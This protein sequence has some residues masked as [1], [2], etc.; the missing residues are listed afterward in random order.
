[1]TMDMTFYEVLSIS[2]QAHKYEIKDAYHKLALRC[3]PDKNPGDIKAVAMMQKINE[4]H[5][6]LYNDH[7]R[8]LY[9]AKLRL[10]R[11]FAGTSHQH[12]AQEH[13]GYQG[14]RK[15]QAYEE[16]QKKQAEQQKQA[17]LQ[18][19]ALGK[20]IIM[21][22]L[23]A[24]SKALEEG[25]RGL[26]DA[27][28]GQ[29]EKDKQA[30]EGFASFTTPFTTLGIDEES[31]QR[32]QEIL[33]QRIRLSVKLGQVKKQLAGHEVEH[34]K[35]LDDLREA[36]AKVWARREEEEDKERE[37]EEAREQEEAAKKAEAAQNEADEKVR[38]EAAAAEAKLRERIWMYRKQDLEERLARNAREEKET[39][40]SAH[41]QSSQVRPSHPWE[42]ALHSDGNSIQASPQDFEACSHSK[43][44]SRVMGKYGC[45]NCGDQ[46]H[47]WIL[48]CPGC[49][50][51]VC[52]RC[53]K[54][55]SVPQ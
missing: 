49:E 18:R 12:T 55:T 19:Q 53:Q 50:K 22:R 29:S 34:Q 8:T 21:D 45:S 25:L 11:P 23:R 54:Q 43:I 14:M 39:H 48:Q 42:N 6:T 26:D 20:M 9:D 7:K 52:T 2:Q 46:Y 35:I 31:G 30:W 36:E 28:R 16:L 40:K 44:W 15:K 47:T 41:H 38:A 17:D 13:D 1:V 24:E 4:A 51:L 10:A 3:H 37:R 5:Q 27:E 33:R 32:C